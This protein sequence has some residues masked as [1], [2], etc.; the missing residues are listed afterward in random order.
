MDRL[1]KRENLLL[2]LILIAAFILRIYRLD[3]ESLWLD[4]THSMMQ[5]DPFISSWQ[6]MFQY[7]GYDQHPPLFY[8]LERCFLTIFKSGNDPE[9]IGR[10]LPA[11]F[12]VLSV[13]AVY[14]L[15]REILNGTLG[16]IAAAITCVNYFNLWYSQ[17]IRD[18]ILV[19]L[20][21][22]LSYVYF[23][24]LIRSR[25]S[26]D[27]WLYTL[28]AAMTTYSHY[29]GIFIVVSQF[30]LAAILVVVDKDRKTYL[31]DFAISGVIIM[32]LYLP[33]VPQL[34]KMGAMKSFWTP[35]V[36]GDFFVD[37][38]KGYF[39]FDNHLL[40][41]VILVL[42][43][44]V[45]IKVVI[46]RRKKW[47][48]FWNNP[49][50]ICFLL[51]SSAVLFVFVLPYIR[52]RVN[53]SMLFPRYTI[54]VLPLLMVSI[55]YGVML[56]PFKPVRMIVV[57]FLVIF[58][59]TNVVIDNNFYS[60]V[61]K[62][63]LREA[64][65]FA[66]TEKTSKLPIFNDEIDWQLNYYIRKSGYSGPFIGGPRKANV[67][68]VLRKSSSRYD[69]GGFWLV[70]VHSRDHYL[71]SATKAALDS[72][73]VLALDAGYL[74]AFAQLYMAKDSVSE[75]TVNDFQPGAV[76]DIGFGKV[77]LIRSGVVTSNGVLLKKGNYVIGVET[78][79]TKAK[80]EF[81]KLAVF[82][83]DKK[84]GDFYTTDD[85]QTRPLSYEQSRNEDSPRI[86][87]ELENELHDPQTNKDRSA[88]LKKIVLFRK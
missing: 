61:H 44:F 9:F 26:R 83:D 46:S 22:T 20:T 82:I 62:T 75:I 47:A 27:L 68:S 41:P 19:F 70:D 42:L 36:P 60:S 1:R 13:W 37:Y 3:H 21:T 16:L 51:L 33:W 86:R 29:Y 57:V 78:K 34:M 8:I 88:F 50:I 81:A 79:G 72:Q 69:A 4:E 85:F 35:P 6:Q 67:D 84:I 43:S 17:E 77:V 7:L 5:S 45:L 54:V 10:I 39:G 23:I 52:S 55:A 64:T 56:I 30:F 12:G 11:I 28:F 49:A 66:T 73:Y 24:R 25:R 76:A 48:D 40:I 65:R 32:L 18:Y 38:F 63:Q 14:L 53:F 31:K 71:D 15:G 58:S 87:I 2:L 59:F 74:D 80:G